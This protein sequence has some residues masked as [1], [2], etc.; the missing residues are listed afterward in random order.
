[1]KATTNWTSPNTGATNSSGFTAFPGGYR[2]SGG[3]Y[4]FVGYF[5]NWWSSTEVVS[6]NAWD[7]E[8]N[9][10]YSV[11]FRVFNNKQNGFS[12]RCLRD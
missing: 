3:S 11:V 9:C 5:G 8:L 2:D 1:M 10:L 12:V 7:R 6:T 4:N